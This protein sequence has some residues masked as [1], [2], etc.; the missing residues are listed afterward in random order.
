MA[1][2]NPFDQKRGYQFGIEIEHK[3]QPILPYLQQKKS[4]IICH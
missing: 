3:K 2:T 1:V 4:V